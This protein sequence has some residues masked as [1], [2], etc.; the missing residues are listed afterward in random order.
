MPIVKMCRVNEIPANAV[1][2][3]VY[4]H[5]S[6]GHMSNDVIGP[7]L[8]ATYDTFTGKCLFESESNGYHDSDFYMTVW[9]DAI[10]APRS[11]CFASTRGWTYP[12]YASHVDATD[13][14]KAK[15]TAW[16]E[17]IRVKAEQERRDNM[18][19]Q[20]RALRKDIRAKIGTGDKF[21]KA[22]KLRRRIGENRFM[23]LLDFLKRSQRSAF[24][25]SLR[26]Q[27]EAWFDCSAPKYD[28]P[29]SPKQ[30]NY[31]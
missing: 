8:Y 18:A 15:F 24:K 27:I 31:I 1:N 22:L 30:W 26:A 9:D 17:A 16:Q 28:M 6:Q 19:K 14:V 13:E 10:K 21:V 29:L 7:R 5:I 3:Q 20:R 4:D 12:C 23:L 11:I 2:V 25:K